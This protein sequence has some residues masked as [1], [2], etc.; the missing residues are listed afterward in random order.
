MKDKLIAYGANIA[1]VCN[2]GAAVQQAAVA[3]KICSF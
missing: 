2:N 1:L 3:L